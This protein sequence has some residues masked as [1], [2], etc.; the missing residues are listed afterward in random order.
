MI[1]AS[2]FY[3]GDFSS[4]HSLRKS[5]VLFFLFLSYLLFKSLSPDRITRLNFSLC[6]CFFLIVKTEQIL[7]LQ[8]AE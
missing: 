6:S 4:T 7:L 2:A 1:R 3:R 8:C 5:N